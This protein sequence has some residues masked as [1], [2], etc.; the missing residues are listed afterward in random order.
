MN[1][2][3]RNTKRSAGMPVRFLD[4]NSEVKKGRRQSFGQN[5]WQSESNAKS[6]PAK[7]STEKAIKSVNK[8]K[9]K[10]KK[11]TSSAQKLSD[12]DTVDMET[13]NDNFGL[14]GDEGDSVYQNNDQRLK[15]SKEKETSPEDLSEDR[16]WE[17]ED[18]LI[19]WEDLFEWWRDNEQ[20]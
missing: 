4:D 20:K 10:E 6:K 15:Q 18:L 13:Q 3:T 5:G 19:Q 12:D 1:R 2:S 14:S 11:S 7:I 9:G 8:T 16:F 17:F